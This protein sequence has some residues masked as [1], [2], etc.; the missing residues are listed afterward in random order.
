MFKMKKIITLIFACLLGL[1]MASAQTFTDDFESYTVGSLLG[2]QSPN[3]GTWS[4]AGGGTDDVNVVSTDN[5]STGGS[6][7]IYFTSTVATGG[8]TDCVLP[9]STS[10]LTTGAFTFTA[11]IKIPSGK[12]AYFNFQGNAT[13]GNMYTLDCWM[14]ANGTLS[15]QNTGTQV[16]LGSHPFDQWFKLTI[17]ANFNSNIWKLS[18]NDTSQGTWQNTN[19]QVYAIDIYP[20]D[21]SASFWVDDVSYNIVPYTLP[22]LDAAVNLISVTNGLVSQTR[23]LS[24]KVRNLSTTTITSFDLSVDQNGGTPV[25]QN[26]TGASLASLATSVVNITSPFTLVAGVNTFRAII[27]NVNGAG[28]DSLASDDTIATSIT[29]V[30]PAAGKMV[31]VE[32]ATGTWCGWCVRGAVYMD[33]MKAKYPGFFAGVA[34]H[35]ADPMVFTAYDAGIG[36]LISGYPT[37]LVDRLA[38]VDPSVMETDFLSRIQIAPKAFIVN[39]ATYDSTT[40]VLKVSLTTTIQQNIT[41]DYRIACV[42]TEDNVTGTASGYNQSNYYSGGSYGVMGGYELL[43]NPVPAIQ[44]HYNHVGRVI[45]PDFPGLPNAFGAS[46]T[47]GQSFTHTFTYTLPTTWNTSKINILGLFIDNTGKIDNASEVTIPEAIN[48]GY[49]IGTEV[50][51]T[52]IADTYDLGSQISL[53]PNPT[54]NNSYITLNLDQKSDVSVAIYE[55]N[56]ALVARKDYGKLSG[57]MLLPIQLTNCSKGMYFINI[58]IDGKTSVKKLVKD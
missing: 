9:F 28:P 49:V 8:P 43:A 35:N 24:V 6:K 14:N 17:D 51:T 2:P 50:G 54:T 10:P 27:S 15:I 16:L 55:V 5:H 29:P 21:A 22:T 45:S 12:D 48:N 19:N 31:A 56:G 44:M 36:T 11:W 34:V 52:G 46:A 57:G 37:A 3:W 30:T 20:S 39:G 58:T 23:N 18:V 41:G 32:E 13:M 1:T 25:V 53:Y 7:S 38:G 26:V 40:R 47:I 4:G 42:L 33:M